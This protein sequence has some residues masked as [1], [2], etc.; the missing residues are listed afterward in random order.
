M[1]H[2]KDWCPSLEILKLLEADKCHGDDHKHAGGV[3]ALDMQDIG[4]DY[5]VVC[6]RDVV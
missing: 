5:C 6:I 2:F 4:V 1:E 3:Q